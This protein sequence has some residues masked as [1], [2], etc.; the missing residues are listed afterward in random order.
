MGARTRRLHH[1]PGA[2]PNAAFAKARAFSPR[3]PEVDSSRILKG[4]QPTLPL[5]QALRDFEATR[6]LSLHEMRDCVS[7]G[8]DLVL[9]SDALEMPRP[10]AI[11]L[12]VKLGVAVLFVAGVPRF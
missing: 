7:K 4:L 3:R 6:A 10:E 5:L 12:L 11:A 2:L 1:Q 9:L 8:S